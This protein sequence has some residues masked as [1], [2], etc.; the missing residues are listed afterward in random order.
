MGFYL[1][2][3][4]FRYLFGLSAFFFYLGLFK[5]NGVFDSS[6]KNTLSDFGYLK[7]SSIFSLTI[8]C[9]I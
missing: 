7:G 9:T 4:L 5:L 1:G 8:A 2:I 6:E 3:R